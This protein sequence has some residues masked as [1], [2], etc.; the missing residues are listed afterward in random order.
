[1]QGDEFKKTLSEI[2]KDCINTY[3]G[4]FYVMFYMISSN[5]ICLALYYIN[6]SKAFLYDSSCI[7]RIK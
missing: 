2:S 7:V 5:G 6:I 1:M 3:K 4:L